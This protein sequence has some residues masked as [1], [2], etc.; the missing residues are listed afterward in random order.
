MIAFVTFYSIGYEAA[1]DRICL[2][3]EQSGIFDEMITVNNEELTEE[4]KNSD[5]FKVK[6]GYGLYSWKPDTIYQALGKLNYGDILVYLDAGCK[7]SENNKEW[8]KYFS[9]L[10][11]AD[12]LAFRLHQRNYH[13][14]RSSVFQEFPTDN[15]LNWKKLFQFGANALILRKTHLSEKFIGEWRSYMINRLDLCGDVSS[16]QMNNE[17]KRLIENR[18]DQTILTALLY[19]YLSTG[20]IASVWEHFEGYDFFRSQ[21]F[22]AARLRTA[23]SENRCM[24]LGFIIHCFI[25]QY[26]YYPIIGNFI[27]HKSIKN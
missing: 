13:W 25:K 4:L 20:K 18:Y 2:E 3:A 6:K 11:K 5:T 1:R 27:W 16:E 10:D 26:L 8:N 14:T 7:I 21:A 23:E 15:D 12:I 24:T 22:L 9:L 19:K 17:D